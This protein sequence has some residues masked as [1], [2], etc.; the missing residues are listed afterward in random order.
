VG[1]TRA[2]VVWRPLSLREILRER[3]LAWITPIGN[4]YVVYT[5]RVV[6]FLARWFDVFRRIVGHELTHAHYWLLD[7]AGRRDPNE[8]HHHPV[9]HGCPMMAKGGWRSR[10][11]SHLAVSPAQ[12]RR[13]CA[14]RGLVLAV[15]ERPP[16]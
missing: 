15:E 11:W 10:D 12:V 4:H 9:S 3:A 5:H 7:R 16:D 8:R 14:D 6:L 13:F 1:F 2:A